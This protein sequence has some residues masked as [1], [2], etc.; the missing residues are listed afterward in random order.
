MTHAYVI[1][2]TLGV[3]LTILIVV[4]IVSLLRKKAKS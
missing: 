1:S 4:A 3:P 2:W